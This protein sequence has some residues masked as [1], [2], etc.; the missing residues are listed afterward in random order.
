[1]KKMLLV[2]D[3]QKDF[4]DGSLGFSKAVELDRKIAN[5]I[6]QAKKDGEIIIFTMDTHKPDYLE[7]QEGKTL[8]VEHCIEGSDGWKLYGETGKTIEN[9]TY[10]KKPTFGGLGL[11][12]VLKPYEN[13]NLEIEICGVVTNMCVISNAV[14]CKATLPES[15][16]TI[17]S[18]LC[19]SFDDVLHAKAIDV[20][21]SM[22]MKII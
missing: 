18:N 17:N 16:I 15:P 6:K 1:M 19:A 2:V 20:M 11:I 13:E 4:V 7:T 22:Q 8:P 9:P 14:I 5:R 21:Q 12:E 10:V 3:F